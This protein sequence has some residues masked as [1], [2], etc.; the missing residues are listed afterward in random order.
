MLHIAI[1]PRTVNGRRV[2]HG[3]DFKAAER[4]YPLYNQWIKWEKEN[5]GKLLTKARRKAR[6]GQK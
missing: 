4:K 5:M 2:I 6:R 3:R 1:P